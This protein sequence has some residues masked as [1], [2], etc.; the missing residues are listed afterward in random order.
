MIFHQFASPVPD[1]GKVRNLASCFS[2]GV[3]SSHCEE[4]EYGGNLPFILGILD[5]SQAFMYPGKLK[6][7]IRFV[8]TD[9]LN[10]KK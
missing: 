10:S 6:I 3:A 9:I 5:G 4:L 2:I 8:E 1:G 7:W